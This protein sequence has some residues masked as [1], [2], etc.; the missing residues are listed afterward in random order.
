[1]I[2]TGAGISAESGIRTFRDQNGLWE[3]HKIEEVATP[4]AFFRNPK[5]VYHFYNLRRAQLKE[6]SV[7]PNPAHHALARLEQE[8]K[9]EFL[10]VSQNVDNLHARAGSKKMISMH[11]QLQSAWC[12]HC[13]KKHFWDQDLAHLDTCPAC[14]KQGQMRPDIVW[15]GE[16][17]YQMEEI[18]AALERCDLF[19]SIGT[20]GNVYPAAG[21]VNAATRAH[22]IEIN[23]RETEISS[24]FQR[25]LVG[26]AGV[27][28]PK[29]VEELKRRS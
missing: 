8:W 22:T 28:V 24:A 16:M 6:P 26:P 19:I 15:F 3:N 12:R 14:Q 21:F 27:E 17:P 4:E 20:S 2:L 18:Y 25:H 29:L 23:N 9:G 11:G 5:L 13:E 1:M 10:L 7:Q